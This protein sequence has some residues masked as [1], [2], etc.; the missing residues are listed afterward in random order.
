MERKASTVSR[1]E[2]SP[3]PTSQDRDMV[4]TSQGDLRH[5]DRCCFQAFGPLL[6]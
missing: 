6:C 4:D 5:S 2:L 3:G 1:E